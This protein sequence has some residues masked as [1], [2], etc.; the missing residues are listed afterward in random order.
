MPAWQSM[1]ERVLFARSALIR[2]PALDIYCTTEKE[3]GHETTSQCTHVIPKAS[4]IKF[5]GTV[6]TRKLSGKAAQLVDDYYEGSQPPLE[7]ELQHELVRLR[8]IPQKYQ[9]NGSW[10]DTMHQATLCHQP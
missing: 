4:R 1:P 5:L 9:G 7:N 3:L 6:G 8:G 2:A 10:V